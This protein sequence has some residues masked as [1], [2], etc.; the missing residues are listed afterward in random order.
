MRRKTCALTLSTPAAVV[1]RFRI[2][3]MRELQ[4]WDADLEQTFG[5][6]EEIAAQCR[7][8]DCAHNGEPGCAVREALQDGTLS[9]ER[10]DSYVKLQRELAA[11]ERR[12][13]V[14]AR[15][16][17]LRTYKIRARAQRKKRR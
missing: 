3:F 14:L 1:I 2:R 6:V 5:D 12:R 8:N 7:F 13:N 4:L 11:L 9:R 10:W 15:K 16:E 17:E